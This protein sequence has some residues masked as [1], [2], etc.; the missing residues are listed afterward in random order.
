[1]SGAQPKAKKQLPE[2][3]R[4]ALRRHHD[5]YGILADESP[6]LA[7][8]GM[9]DSHSIE[10]RILDEMS[11]GCAKVPNTA[12]GGIQGSDLVAR[13]A[14]RLRRVER[15]LHLLRADITVKSRRLQDLQAENAQLRRAVNSDNAST[16][17]LVAVQDRERENSGLRKQIREMEDFL[18]DY[19]LVWVGNDASAKQHADIMKPAERH[20]PE[21]V[22]VSGFID[23]LKELT[24]RIR[25]DH[26]V[27]VRDGRR[28]QF[29]HRDAQVVTVYK[30]GFMLQN[31][32]FRRYSSEPALTFVRD[33]LDG[34]FPSE[35]RQTYPEGV[36]FDVVDKSAELYQSHA[37]TFSGSGRALG[38][39]VRTIADNVA[40]D[41]LINNETLLTKLPKFVVRNGRLIDIRED[42]RRRINGE[43]M[44]AATTLTRSIPNGEA[45]ASIV[46]S[47]HVLPAHDNSDG[48]TTI[49]VRDKDGTRLVLSMQIDD[50]IGKLRAEIDKVRL[51]SGAYEV[52][53]A[54]PRKSLAD[55]ETT[56]KAANLIPSAT[57]FLQDC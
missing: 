4:E 3:L 25:D 31:G 30:D 24:A 6:S 14:S 1:M 26:P 43:S 54:Y 20:S 52:R 35:F 50:T 11:Q 15:A 18:A 36:Q 27:V 42:V 45:N 8:Q 49:Q 21:A 22:D 28:A 41:T 53:T 32:P 33:V 57:V 37:A 19:G 16:S 10:R 47:P 13:M 56:L 46:V 48:S 9:D 40:P 38:K 17:L 29:K 7:F 51:S 55:P 23:S 2:R 5:I 39:N 12:S 34:F 44:Q